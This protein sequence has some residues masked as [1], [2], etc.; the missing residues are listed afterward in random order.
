MHSKKVTLPMCNVSKGNIGVESLQS[1]PSIG[2]GARYTEPTYIVVCTHMGVLKQCR[3]LLFTQTDDLTLGLFV[4]VCLAPSLY[5]YH[6][7]MLTAPLHSPPQ[8]RT[9]IF[10]RKRLWKGS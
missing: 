9:A 8:D 3:L 10:K 2:S 6:V 1:L 5:V 4:H 7:M